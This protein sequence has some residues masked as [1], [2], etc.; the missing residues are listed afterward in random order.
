MI[1]SVYCSQNRD[2]KFDLS[3]DEIFTVLEQKSGLLWVVLQEATSEEINSILRDTFIFHPLSIEDCESQGYQTPKV[4][5]FENHLFILSHALMPD[6]GSLEAL[7]TQELDMFLGGN[8]V[9]CSYHSAEMPPVDKVWGRLEKDHRLMQNGADF[10]CHAILDMLVDDYMPLIDRMD[11]EIEW[12]EDKV[13]EKPSPETLERILALKHSTLTLRRIIAPQ[14]E[15]MNRLSRDEFDLIA[16]KHRIY[17]RDI[18]D[19]LVRIQDLS[20][21]V[22]DIVSGT[23]D[24]YLS[25]TSNRLN[26][27]MKALTIVSTIF[28]PLT[29]IAGVYGMNFKYFPEINWPFGYL[30]VWI[31]F[32][33]I[34]IAM[35]WFFKKRGWI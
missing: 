6:H 11:E 31:L 32:F 22:R 25:A 13:L 21:S 15:I 30:Y 34:L 20:E 24:I 3:R 14:R 8:Y 26:E 18:Y 17:Y 7:D 19:H 5:D 28:L 23:L 29:F 27:V 10:L 4:D 33:V 16:P 12:M 2:I 1:R 35:L 9:V